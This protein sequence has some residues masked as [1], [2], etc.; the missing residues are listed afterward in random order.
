MTPLGQ[1]PKSPTRALRLVERYRGA[2]RLAR[3]RRTGSRPL[4]GQF[5]REEQPAPFE[6]RG[7]CP[8]ERC[9]SGG[10]AALQ[11]SPDRPRLVDPSLRHRPAGCP[12]WVLPPAAGNPA[13][14]RHQGPRQ[15]NAH[16]PPPV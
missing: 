8:R 13:V 7:A 3:G 5:V 6:V 14:T 16:L 12:P 1:P 4:P 10:A 15:D 11:E 9:V 2:Q